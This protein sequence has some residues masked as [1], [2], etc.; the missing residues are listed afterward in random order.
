MEYFLYLFREQDSFFVKPGEV[1]SL[2]LNFKYKTSF[3]ANMHLF[4]DFTILEVFE[5]TKSENLVAVTLKNTRLIEVCVK[6]SHKNYSVRKINNINDFDAPWRKTTIPRDLQVTA[7]FF[8]FLSDDSTQINESLSRYFS[9]NYRDCYFNESIVSQA[10]CEV[11]CSD[12]R[13]YLVGKEVPITCSGDRSVIDLIFS[14]EIRGS[15]ELYVVEIKSKTVEVSDAVAC[16]CRRSYLSKVFAYVKFFMPNFHSKI[17]NYCGLGVNCFEENGEFKFILN[18]TDYY[19]V[20][21]MEEISK[22]DSKL[23]QEYLQNSKNSSTVLSRK[24]K[25][26]VKCL[27]D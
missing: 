14:T 27:F 22:E 12:K 5:S 1:C 25:K 21:E 24:K 15:A 7:D 13:L 20:E 2:E 17:A 8:T 10:L 11:I 4:V 16:I 18:K 19:N 6:T 3:L 9:F 26:L 23:T